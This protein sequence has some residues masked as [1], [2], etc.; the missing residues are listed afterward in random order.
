MWANIIKIEFDKQLAK[1]NRNEKIDPNRFFADRLG[2]YMCIWYSLLYCVLDEIIKSGVDIPGLHVDYDILD[3]LRKFRN[4]VFHPQPEYF[5]SMLF[6]LIKESNSALEIRSIHS[7]LG[8]FFLQ[9]MK[10]KIGMKG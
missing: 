5:S 8:N 10:R 9:E 3:K 7:A 2:A 6:K 1:M 4:A